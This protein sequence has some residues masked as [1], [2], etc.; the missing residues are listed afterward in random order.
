M[1]TKKQYPPS[2][3]RRGNEVFIDE[4]KKYV[5][6]AYYNNHGTW[7]GIINGYR[8]GH[9]IKVVRRSGYETEYDAMG[10]VDR[11]LFKLAKKE[12]LRLNAEF[13]KAHPSPRQ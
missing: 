5:G 10:Y 1:K 6:S 4:K 3:V 12:M 2:V 9:T 8:L 7:T 11:W 13:A